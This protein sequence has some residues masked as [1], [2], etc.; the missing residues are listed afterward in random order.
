[1]K[2][3]FFEV[4]IE[5]SVQDSKDSVTMR[6]WWMESREHIRRSQVVV[7]SSDRFLTAGYMSC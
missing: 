2:C 4:V 7:I 3:R 6:I 5:I 1:M